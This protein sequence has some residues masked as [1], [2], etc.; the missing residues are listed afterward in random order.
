M[1]KWKNGDSNIEEA[2]NWFEEQE[3][4]NQLTAIMAEDYEI[5]DIQKGIQ[6]VLVA[7]EKEKAV[8]ERN[9]ILKELDREDITK[10]EKSSLERKLSE[11]IIKLARM[12]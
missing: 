3:I 1:K 4:V 8:E 5:T 10:E 9:D 11:I 7:Y 6:D 12:K 2:V